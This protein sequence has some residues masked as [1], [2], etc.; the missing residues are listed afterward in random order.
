MTETSCS[1]LVITEETD[2]EGRMSEL[3]RGEL[4][5]RLGVIVKSS[6]GISLEL[7][8]LD[9]VPS[10]SVWSSSGT[11]MERDSSELNPHIRLPD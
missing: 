2:R 1:G 3:L 7:T 11:S 8:L 9:L 4:A 5:P 10:L 6:S